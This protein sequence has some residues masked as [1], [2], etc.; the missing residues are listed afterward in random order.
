MA[1]VVLVL[2][3]NESWS[4][5]RTIAKD[6]DPSSGLAETLDLQAHGR[7][8]S[9]CEAC[10]AV[11]ACYRRAAGA[12]LYGANNANGIL[13]SCGED[14]RRGRPADANANNALLRVRTCEDLP[15]TIHVQRRV[16]LRFSFMQ[17][18]RRS[19]PLYFSNRGQFSIAR[20]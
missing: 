17:A 1:F 14:W 15:V 19:A 12:N 3:Y 13:A 5:P 7:G 8:V 18:G 9:I 10:T 11:H 4:T 16:L 2:S 20:P 6:N